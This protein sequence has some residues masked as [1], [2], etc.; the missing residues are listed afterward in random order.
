M[1]YPIF[2][3]QPR[4]LAG[5]A[6]LGSLGTETGAAECSDVVARSSQTMEKS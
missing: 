2:L 6:S 3:S 4:S 5:I 1:V